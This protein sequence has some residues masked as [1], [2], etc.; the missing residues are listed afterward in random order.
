VTFASINTLNG[1]VSRVRRDNSALVCLGSQAVGVVDGVEADELTAAVGSSK[2]AS[3]GISSVLIIP[4]FIIDCIR[5]ATPNSSPRS[6]GAHSY[7]CAS[8]CG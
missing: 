2:Q 8:R 6:V 3:V 7:T 1:V 4:S 5:Q